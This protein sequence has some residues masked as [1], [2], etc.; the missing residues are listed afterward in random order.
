[1]NAGGGA[2]DQEPRG[3][4]PPG[5]RRQLLRCQYGTAGGAEDVE[6]C[7]Q[8]VSLPTES[9]LMNDRLLARAN[10]RPFVR[11]N[12]AAIQPTIK[13]GE[14]ILQRRS[15]HLLQR[16]RRAA[17]ALVAGYMEGNLFL[18]TTPL[19]NGIQQRSVMSTSHAGVIETADGQAATRVHF[20]WGGA[21][22]RLHRRRASLQC[23]MHDAGY[24]A[25]LNP[26]IK[27]ITGPKD[28]HTQETGNTSFDSLP[29]KPY[30]PSGQKSMNFHKRSTIWDDQ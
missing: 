11:R 9:V 8:A 17:S 16:R 5:L 25:L 3:I 13:L 21:R 24:T 29:C 18:A 4:G 12:P 2:V 15:K 22:R 6:A 7:V 30:N 20:D 14:V 23:R 19:N 27:M 28:R 26:V 10:A 1:V